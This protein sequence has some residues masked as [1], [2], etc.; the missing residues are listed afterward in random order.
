MTPLRV[1]SVASECV[2]LVKTGGLADVAG[3]P[4]RR[5]GAGGHRDGDASARLSGCPG[6]GRKRQGARLIW[7]SFS[8][9]R[10]AVLQGELGGYPL[11]L[12]D[13]PHLFDREGGIYLG[14]D[15]DDWPDNPKRFAALSLAAARIGAEGAMGWRPRSCTCMTGRRAWRPVYLRQLGAEGRVGSLMTI[16]NIAFQGLAPAAMLDRAC[17]APPGFQPE[18]V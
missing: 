9:A 2:P 16:H 15:G 1:L 5:A 11:Y 12:L 7:A 10:P 8:A 18:R 3:R 6:K 14:P 4:A 13:A 17:P